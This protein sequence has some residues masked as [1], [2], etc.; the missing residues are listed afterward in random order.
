[1]NNT[2]NNQL[3]PAESQ[4][5]ISVDQKANTRATLEKTAPQDI[6]EEC[7]RWR[8]MGPTIQR[9][10]TELNEFKQF[11]KSPDELQAKIRSLTDKLVD[12]IHQRDAQIKE[13]VE[14]MS[15]D[16]TNKETFPDRSKLN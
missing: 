15:G 1:M 11:A 10:L 16:I 6:F 3:S 13:L 4:F 12:A 9:S 5:G 14:Y 2:S 8:L 7:L